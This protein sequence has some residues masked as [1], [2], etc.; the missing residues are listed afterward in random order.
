M[1]ENGM[2][3]QSELATMTG[4]DWLSGEIIS[5]NY[6]RCPLEIKLWLFKVISSHFAFHYLVQGLGTKQMSFQWRFVF[7][8]ILSTDLKWLGAELGILFTNMRI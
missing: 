2:V 3:C 4:S 5:Q 6:K 7:S 1:R 8:H